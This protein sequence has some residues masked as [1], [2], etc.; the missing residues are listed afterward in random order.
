MAKRSGLFM[1]SGS[2]LRTA[3]MKRVGVIEMRTSVI[4]MRSSVIEGVPID[5]GSAVG[6]VGC[7]VVEHRSVVP[8]EPPVVPPPTKT[9]E[10][11]D[12]K[13]RAEIQVWP[14]IDSRKP[15]PAWIGL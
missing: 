5:E 11:A 3:A 4:E 15:R 12:T 10:E 6:E 9:G 14:G 13:A 8:I 2:S 1:E 7:V